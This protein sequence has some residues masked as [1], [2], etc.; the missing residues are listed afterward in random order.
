DNWALL[1]AQDLALSKNQPLVV[2]VDFVQGFLG[3]QYRQD[4]FE[5]EG[6]KQV[7]DRLGNYDIPLCVLGPGDNLGEF[8]EDFNFGSVV[9]D[10]SPL[11]E[12]RKKRDKLARKVSVKT[13]EVDTHNIVPCWVAS[14]KQ[15]YA[16]R[17]IRP[18]INSKLGEFME[19]FPNLRSQEKDWGGSFSNPNFDSLISKSDYSGNVDKVGWLEPGPRG[20]KGQMNKFL[21]NRL[22]DYSEHRNNANKWVISDLS[23]YFNFGHIAP[24][25]VALEV[26]SRPG[27][28]KE[29]KNEF[30]EEMII[31]RELSDN[32]C[33]YNDQYDSIKGFPDWAQ[34]TLK[35]HKD[36]ERE[37][38]YTKNEFENAETH[39]ELWNTAQ[40][41][42]VETGKMHGYLRMY[43]AKKILEWTNTP[44]YALKIS[45]YLNDKYELDGRNPN[46]YVGCAWSIGG[47]HDRAW[48]ERKI[49]GKVR[50]M[51]QA[52]C[53]R[54]FDVEKYINRSFDF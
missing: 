54:K 38:V 1:F 7:A 16:A 4:I 35:K 24:Q 28:R 51:T 46:G 33:F 20:A 49:F 40:K 8:L 34:K 11:R 44:S 15:E 53:R 47:V 5:V 21:E 17:T 23:P 42:M 29:D 41:E 13:Y 48:Q 50:Y 45:I 3:G 31:R 22:K 19:D 26:K 32:F 30:L 12:N 14:D 52:A 10:F 43:W 2:V 27:T 9:V 37:Y 39:D 18:K 25:R 6:I 36:D